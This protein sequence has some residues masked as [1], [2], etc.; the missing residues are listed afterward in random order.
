[1]CAPR[2]AG[3]ET[4]NP[5]APR[6]NVFNASDATIAAIIVT[7]LSCAVSIGAHGVQP[8][9]IAVIAALCASSL[10][11]G[12]ATLALPI[13]VFRPLAEYLLGFA[14]VSIIIFAVSFAATLSAGMAA[15]AAFLAAITAAAVCL[16]RRRALPP[17]APADALAVLLI[18]TAT[19]IW[20]WQAIG[21][22]PGLMHSGVFHAWQDYFIHAGEIAQFAQL[23]ALHGTS[24]FALGAP[25]PPYH[26]A[27]YMLPAALCSLA[28]L[29]ALI[30]ATAFWTPLG[31]LLLGFGAAVL[32]GVLGGSACG[33]TALVFVLLLPG[34]SHYGLHNPFFDFHWL[35]QI[36][37]TGCYAVALACLAL[38]AMVLWLRERRGAWLL[39]AVAAT[40]GVAL[41]RVHIFVP[42]SATLALSF[43]LAWR[44]AQPWQKAAALAAG[45][46]LLLLCLAASE[47]VQR[48]PHFLSGA[49][50]PLRNLLALTSPEP[51]PYAGLFAW[52]C[53]RLWRVCALPVGVVLVLA[54]AFGLLLPLYL[55]GLAWRARQQQNAP[56]D[57]LPLF[58][59]L[60]YCACMLLIPATPKEPMEFE[61]R[62]FVLV[63]VALAVWCA[64]FAAAAAASRAWPVW[65]HRLAVAAPVI[66]LATPLALQGS[67]QSSALA[68]GAK[69]S[70]IEV[71]RGLIE[72]AAFLR[73]HA[74][75]GAP[76][77]YTT[78]PLDDA[79]VALSEHPAF[80][81]GTDFLLIQSGLD[82]AQAAERSIQ[83]GQLQAATGKAADRIA[84]G[85]G[86]SWIVTFP[87]LPPTSPGLTLL[88]VDGFTVAQLGGLHQ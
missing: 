16:R 65:S 58:A 62:P 69:A 55:A 41:F 21:A 37:S 52:I 29:P 76:I 80:Y 82:D 61:H 44:P 11:I 70:A 79:L 54:G 38:A 2:C 66:L 88:D 30:C 32:G 26:Y 39:W 67:A 17:A 48:A 5:P 49:Y 24:I 72:A 23:G 53:A 15:G 1:M 6:T 18:C 28:F 47:H 68:W 74:A 36:S 34:A 83:L 25:L 51:S 64:K 42:L 8:A 4:M 63:Y 78:G 77:A 71:P 57:W 12:R 87:P 35:M 56:E 27:S 13:A 45:M 7:T 60:A 14:L 3:F 85:L 59:I 43:L 75:Q 73:A 33:I 46:A 10:A 31:F 19:I 81:P 22:V 9:S 86:V 20:S 50:H 84:A 40:A